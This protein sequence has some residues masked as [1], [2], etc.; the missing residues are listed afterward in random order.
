MPV[1][2][3]SP[4]VDWIPLVVML[5]LSV[6][7]EARVFINNVSRF[8]SCHVTLHGDWL[9]MPCM[10]TT[11]HAYRS[12]YFKRD[13]QWH[14]STVTAQHAKAMGTDVAYDNG[15]CALEFLNAYNALASYL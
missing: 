13:K 3:V 12:L 1:Y 5:S 7:V 2:H 15:T 10:L 8:R 6:V 14:S 4:A 9:I 11:W